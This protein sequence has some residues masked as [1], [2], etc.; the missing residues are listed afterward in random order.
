AQLVCEQDQVTM[1][2]LRLA[3]TRQ[4][5]VLHI[6]GRPSP[7]DPDAARRIAALRRLARHSLR[8]SA[9]QA[10]STSSAPWSA[11]PAPSNRLLPEDFHA[12]L[13]AGTMRGPMAGP[14]CAVVL[15]A[16]RPAALPMT[17][18]PWKSSGSCEA[19]TRI[20]LRNRTI[21]AQVSLSRSAKIG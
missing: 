20:G 11:P 9:G 8:D 4:Y 15:P 21:H 6:A 3:Q 19:L 2:L 18:S 10:S 7:Q 1:S 14:S 17:I 12:S 13:G 5:L 16:Y